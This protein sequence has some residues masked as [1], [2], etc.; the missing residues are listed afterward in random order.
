MM[1]P[2]ILEDAELDRLS[3]I[4][5]ANPVWKLRVSFELFIVRGLWQTAADCTRDFS[6]GPG[7]LP[8]LPEQERIR[9]RLA[10]HLSTP[11]RQPGLDPQ[12]VVESRLE[13]SLEAA[14]CE[15]RDGRWFEKLTHHTWP[16]RGLR[17][18]A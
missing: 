9:I 8:L 12:R 10:A 2:I 7:M 18:H 1:T 4:Y 15:C 16:R 17:R 11:R 5:A 3:E 14:G 13:R 6:R